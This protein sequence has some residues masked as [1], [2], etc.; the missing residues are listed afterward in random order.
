MSALEREN[1]ELSKYPDL[2]PAPMCAHIHVI[3]HKIE[4]GGGLC[5]DRWNCRDC[6]HEFIPVRYKR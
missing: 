1:K 5:S 6:G 3:Y 4:I 2:D